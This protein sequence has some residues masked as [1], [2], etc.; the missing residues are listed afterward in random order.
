MVRLRDM[1]KLQPPSSPREG[2]RT[3][4]RAD[5]PP[6]V[7]EGLDAWFARRLEARGIRPRRRR[8]FR[9]PVTR[10]LALAGLFAAIGGVGWAVTSTHHSTTT[11]GKHRG[12]HGRARRTAPISW[13]SVRVDVLNGYGGGGAATR[14][15]QALRAKG[16]KV[17][18]VGNAG[19]HAQKT[20]VIFARGHWLQARAVARRLRLGPPRPIAAAHGVPANATRSVAILIGTQGLPLPV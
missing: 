17:G 9:V 15:A 11:A 19:S 3:P 4:A 7:D 10:L 12:A 2:S 20:L 5:R 18:K 16:W 13:R 8:S 1:A 14:A 6:R